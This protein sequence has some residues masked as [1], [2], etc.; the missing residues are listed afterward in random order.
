MKTYKLLSITAIALAPFFNANSANA[1][2]LSHVDLSAG[3]QTVQE[4]YDY[5]RKVQAVKSNLIYAGYELQSCRQDN[6]Y[7]FVKP[8]E[9]IFLKAS[10]KCIYFVPRTDIG[11]SNDYAEISTEVYYNTPTMLHNE[12]EV[13]ARYWTVY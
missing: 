3:Y 2:D 10:V 12:G 1:T 4:V 8:T 7:Y 5:G 13:T 11:F 6:V 9:N